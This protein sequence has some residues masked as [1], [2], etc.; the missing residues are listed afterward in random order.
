[1]AG[2]F[3]GYN[4][5]ASV[6]IPKNEPEKKRIRLFFEIFFRKFWRLLELN[7][8]YFIFCIPLITAG[9]ATA[10]ITKVL[11]NFS[12]EKHAFVFKDFFDSF[13]KNFR[14]SFF[15][16]IINIAAI[17]VFGACFYV[18]P[19]MGYQSGN[20]IW[21]L[22]FGVT[23]FVALLFMV[24]NFYAFI[25]IVSTDISFKDVV[26]NSFALAV[27]ALKTNILTLFLTLFILAAFGVLAFF[28]RG[29]IFLTPFMPAT[30]AGLVIVFNCYPIVQKY[31]IDPY[32]E[33]KG[34]VNPEIA[35]EIVSPDETVFEDMGGKE[36][37]VV[38]EKSKKRKGKI[39]S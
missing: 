5:K 27:M 29:V 34:E 39:I 22:L 32:Y 17:I 9:P 24:M 6:G 19:V 10:G 30:I 21:F 4:R 25:M 15:I 3:G 13:M 36:K 33:Q 28:V 2:I 14:K 8:I 26:K 31:I 18:Y 37:P 23:I 12:Q 11:K 1:M 16:G 7:F 20:I 35:K 38:T